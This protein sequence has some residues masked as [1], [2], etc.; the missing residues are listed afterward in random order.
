[1]SIP[2]EQ[3]YAH[4][5]RPSLL[6]GLAMYLTT[7]DLNV[8]LSGPLNFIEINWLNEGRPMV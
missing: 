1:M 3:L 6:E 8:D 7:A 4:T 2:C 5:G